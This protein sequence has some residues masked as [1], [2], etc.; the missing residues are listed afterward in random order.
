MIRCFYRLLLLLILTI[1]VQGCFSSDNSAA[2]NYETTVVVQYVSDINGAQKADVRESVDIQSITEYELDGYD[3][4][5]WRLGE[6]SVDDAISIAKEFENL[7]ID[8]KSERVLSQA[9]L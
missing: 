9:P 4:D 1:T 6:T 2:S 5:E 7:V 8:A 3:Y